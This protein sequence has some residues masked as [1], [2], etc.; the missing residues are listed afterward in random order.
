MV[1]AAQRLAHDF[2]DRP[3][4][5][6]GEAIS[7]VDRLFSDWPNESVTR[8]TKPRPSKIS[9]EHLR[10][11]AKAAV[12]DL[13][14]EHS[15]ENVETA[16]RE[17]LAEAGSR[18]V[19]GRASSAPEDIGPPLP[20][21]TEGQIEAIKQRGRER[22]WSGRTT[23]RMSPFEWVRDNYSEWMPGLLQSHLKTADP[24]LYLAFVQRVTRQGRPDWLDVPS[25]NDAKLRTVRSTD[26]LAA[27]K[28]V[29]NYR[30]KSM[31]RVR[32]RRKNNI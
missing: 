16:F 18:S 10:R 27:L 13:L 9:T 11:Q 20:E 8:Q 24:A 3:F 5:V 6:M 28:A 21:L 32:E 23:Y 17:A 30:A 1:K 22:P 29:R 19:A 7:S 25:A 12:S 2:L 14:D 31:R 26:E 15:L 4:V